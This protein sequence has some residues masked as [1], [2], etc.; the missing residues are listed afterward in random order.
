MPNLINR[1]EA[2][3][4]AARIVDNLEPER[5]PQI[6]ALNRESAIRQIVDRAAVSKG[7]YERGYLTNAVMTIESDLNY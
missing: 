5:Y 3:K 7:Q 4:I 6:K 2:E 1:E